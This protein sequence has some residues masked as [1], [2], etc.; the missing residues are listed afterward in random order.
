MYTIGPVNYGPP[1]YDIPQANDTSVSTY[2][3]SVRL[4]IAPECVLLIK[5]FF[6]PVDMHLTQRPC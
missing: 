5:S 6:L 4:R 1:Y 3:Y 2:I